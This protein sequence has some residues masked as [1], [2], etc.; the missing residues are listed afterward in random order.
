MEDVKGRHFLTA[1]KAAVVRNSNLPALLGIDSLGKHNAIIKC[2]TGEI[3]FL[4]DE[5]ADVKPKGEFVHC[6]MKR[7]GPNGHWWLPI[8]RFN[9]AMIKMERGHL[10]AAGIAPDKGATSSSATAE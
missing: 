3:W 10:A 6:Q 1:Y 7:N 8:G 2:R 9:D 5:G 4:G